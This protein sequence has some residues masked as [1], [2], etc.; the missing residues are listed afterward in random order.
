MKPQI[1]VTTSEHWLRLVETGEKE[2]FIKNSRKHKINTIKQPKKNALTKMN[3]SNAKLRKLIFILCVFFLSAFDCSL[4]LLYFSS[5]L[6]VH[7]SVY[8]VGI[9]DARNKKKTK[10]KSR[11]KQ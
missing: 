5:H 8:F 2:N 4:L 6:L 9:S 7:A 1:P 3:T 11:K 10:L